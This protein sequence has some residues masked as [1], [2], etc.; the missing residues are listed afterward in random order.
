[1]DNVYLLIGGNLGNRME[2]LDNAIRLIDSRA[3]KISGKS[4]VY[5]TAAWGI[6]DQKSFLN[7][8]V[9]IITPHPPAALLDIILEIERALGRIRLEKNG[10][11]LIDIDILFYGSE[12]ISEP[13][14]KIPHPLLQERKFAL[15]PMNNVCPD[16]IHPVLKKTVKQLLLECKDPLKAELYTTTIG[17]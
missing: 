5:E 13:R 1:M 17:E 6:T 7:Q 4:A 3:G 10:P 14:L 9:R 2:N 12:I 15:E 8:A 16:F 11:R